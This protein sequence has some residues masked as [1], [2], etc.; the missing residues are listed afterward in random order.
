LSSIP[1]SIPSS[2]LSSIRSAVRWRHVAVALLPVLLCSLPSAAPAAI[3]A[4]AV[5]APVLMVF[6]DSL[7]AE[8]G[9]PQG[10]GWVA[11]LERRL[12]SENLG[13]QV[14]NASISGETTEPT[15]NTWWQPAGKPMPGHCWS[16]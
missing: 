9:L 13:W 10:S 4:S 1:S 11:L 16:A 5:P 12:K 3:A 2:V 15:S 8:Y 6:G 14:V 7:S